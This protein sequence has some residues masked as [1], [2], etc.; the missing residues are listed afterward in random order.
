MDSSSQSGSNNDIPDNQIIGNRMSPK[1]MANISAWIFMLDDNRVDKILGDLNLIKDGSLYMKMERL[2]SN[3]LGQYNPEDFEQTN[4]HVD[5]TE[6]QA[7]RISII[8]TCLQETVQAITDDVNTRQ[9]NIFSAIPQHSTP[10]GSDANLIQNRQT[11]QITDTP[12]GK[13]VNNGRNAPYSF[14]NSLGTPS[15]TT[16]TTTITS[17]TSNIASHMTAP[18][19]P[20]STHIP[21]K[22]VQFQNTFT[23]DRP[24]TPHLPNIYLNINPGD[25]F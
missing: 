23:Y 20:S 9:N 13:F 21:Q 1:T 4:K 15:T 19:L 18:H 6:W 17:S 3:I 11:S 22:S 14:F 10:T 12:F 25:K 24:F 16:T 8:E 2:R 5:E 7:R